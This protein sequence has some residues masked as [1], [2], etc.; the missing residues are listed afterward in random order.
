MATATKRRPYGLQDPAYANPNDNQP[1]NQN[2][3]GMQQPAL[4]TQSGPTVTIQRQNVS[5]PEVDYRSELIRARERL[6]QPVQ[7]FQYNREA[8]P[9]YQS[10]LAAARSNIAREQSATNARLRAQGQGRSSFSE[11]LA[12]QVAARTMAD[13]ETNVVP[14]LINQAYQRYLNE[15]TMRRN[16]LQDYLNIT[17]MLSNL[18]QRDI[19]NQR[20]MAELTGRIDYTPEAREVI[21][22]VLDLKRQ[23]ESGGVTP[24]Q[25]A[26]Y[27]SQADLLRQRLAMMGVNPDVVGANTDYQ[28]ALRN[29]AGG[30]P[31]LQAQGMRFDQEMAKRQQQLAEQAQRFSQDMA[32]RQFEYQQLRDQIEDERY[33]QKFDE[34]VRRWGLEFAANEAYRNGQLSISRMNAATSAASA[35]NAARNA[36]YNRLMQLWQMTGR[37]PAGLENY[38]IQPGQTLPAEP[39]EPYTPN[40]GTVVEQLNQQFGQVDELGR[41]TG[42]PSN[43][44]DELRRAIISMN[45]PDEMTDILLGMYGLPTIPN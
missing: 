32:Q 14:A 27:R 11:S 40:L 15:Q 26:R 31:T 33:K 42:I 25:L 10:A 30:I 16:Q 36:E 7:P 9:A 39:S 13:L 4:A 5:T 38:G 3:M 19:E 44:R 37:A 20:A 21:S 8:D 12:Q 45:L 17:N 28:T 35:A 18:D 6:M 29:I 41:F 43:R 23:A 34:D 22:Q 24:E 2:R 1:I